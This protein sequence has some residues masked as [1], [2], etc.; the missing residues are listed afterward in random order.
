[1]GRDCRNL[2]IIRKEDLYKFPSMD[3]PNGEINELRD[4]IVIVEF[5]ARNTCITDCI[6]MEDVKNIKFVLLED[7]D[8]THN[9]YDIYV[10]GE[11]KNEYIDTF[12]DCRRDYIA[13]LNNVL[14]TIDLGESIITK[15]E[16]REIVE[17]YV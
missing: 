10:N 14:K 3:L 12:F 13:N 6:D 2:L 1:M 8:R 9:T 5:C 16:L 15:E 11:K 7:A 4:D 17:K